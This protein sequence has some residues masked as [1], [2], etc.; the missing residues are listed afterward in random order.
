MGG[1]HGEGA[2]GMLW[3]WLGQILSVHHGG[4]YIMGLLTWRGIM[5][6]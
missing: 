2:V 6:L 1:C 3:P 5:G 4:K